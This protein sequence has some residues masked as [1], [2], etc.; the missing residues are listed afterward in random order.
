MYIAHIR[1]ANADAD[2]IPYSVT[3][4]LGITN[5]RHIY[6]GVAILIACVYVEIDNT[7][8]FVQ[9]LLQGSNNT[10]QR[11]M[12]EQRAT[13]PALLCELLSVLAVNQAVCE[14]LGQAYDPQFLRLFPD[15][16]A[17][18]RTLG[19][20]GFNTSLRTGSGLAE[21]SVY[22]VAVQRAILLLAR[23][24]M[25]AV[26]RDDYTPMRDHT[27]T[28]LLQTVVPLYCDGALDEHVLLL[29]VHV[30]T[31][32]KVCYDDTGGKLEN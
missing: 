11:L 5:Q 15:C 9:A 23:T 26:R 29:L 10:W 31:I 7:P 12:N 28:P 25:A 17:V 14:P 16:L 18:Y 19:T 21:P 27:I 20:S 24:Y 30:S 1:T 13:E 6:N 4:H 32:L 2:D 22:I 8:A 3:A